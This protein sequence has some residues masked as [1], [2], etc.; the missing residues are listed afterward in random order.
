MFNSEV[1]KT[2]V[3]DQGFAI[4]ADVLSAREVNELLG[5]LEMISVTMRC[6]EGVVFS[7]FETSWMHV[8]R[9]AN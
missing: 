1:V 8:P 5:A 9:C 6:G 3:A 2:V 7:P 4:C